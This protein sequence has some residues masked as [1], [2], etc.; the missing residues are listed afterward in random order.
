MLHKRRFFL[1]VSGW[2][3]LTLLTIFA[4][5]L[6]HWL[7]GDYLASLQ[8]ALPYKLLFQ[9][10]IGLF[11]LSIALIALYFSKEQSLPVTL[12]PPTDFKEPLNS[13][14]QSLMEHLDAQEKILLSRYIDND[15][16]HLLLDPFSP[17]AKGLGANRVLF[18]QK[19]SII[20][21]TS[22]R[23]ALGAFTI[24]E[25]AWKYL[26]KHPKSIRP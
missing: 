20:R 3:L 26:K 4:D 19:D 2:L 15:T 14:Q 18:M 13:E 6:L 12:P 22:G 8:L 5:D 24:H 10:T 23:E 9:I 7:T 1:T 11:F 17:V 16:K 25:W 21:D